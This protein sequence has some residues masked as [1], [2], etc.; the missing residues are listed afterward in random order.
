MAKDNYSKLNWGNKLWYKIYISECKTF[1]KIT[2]ST[3]V[4]NGC[5]PI[6]TGPQDVYL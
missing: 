5:C 1:E 3:S 6:V 2:S 4:Q